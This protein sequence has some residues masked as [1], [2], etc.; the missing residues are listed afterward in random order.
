[1]AQLPQNTLTNALRS[2]YKNLQTTWDAAGAFSTRKMDKSMSR[3]PKANNPF[4][5]V[6]SWAFPFNMFWSQVRFSHPQSIRNVLVWETV[7]GLW[8]QRSLS[9]LRNRSSIFL[10][11]A[12]KFVNSTTTA[13]LCP[14]TETMYFSYYVDIEAEHTCDVTDK[15]ICTSLWCGKRKRKKLEFRCKNYRRISHQPLQDQAYI[16]HQPLSRYLLFVFSI[17]MNISDE[18]IIWLFSLTTYPASS[19]YADVLRMNMP[20]GYVDAC[21]PWA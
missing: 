11:A 9:P 2:P 17:Q 12:C 19:K 6:T 10:V 5:R 13:T 15:F 14:W 7:R 8:T 1:M 16:K 4:L 18:L 21:P 20:H 3:L